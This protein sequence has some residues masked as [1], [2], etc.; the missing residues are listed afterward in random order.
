MARKLLTK[1]REKWVSQRRDPGVMRG[2]PIRPSAAVEARYSAKIDA[3]VSELQSD[4]AQIIREWHEQPSTETYFATDLSVTD[5]IKRRFKHLWVKWSR[6]MDEKVDNVVDVFVNQSNKANS[7]SVHA[8]LKKLSGGLSL[9]TRKLD[10]DSTQV[11]KAAAAENV[12]LIKSIPQQYL[13]RI[14]G[15]V[16]RSI[17]HPQGRDYLIREIK[18]TNQVTER[19]ATMIASDQTRKVNAAL[20]A[21]RMQKVGVKKFEWVHVA[22]SHPRELHVHLDGK[23]CKWD[24]PPV[25]QRNPIIKGYPAQLPNCKCQSVPVFEFEE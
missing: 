12:A 2:D 16:Y 8:S 23:I 6:M 10:Y 7:A 22:S 1:R 25:I 14:E 18:R 5:Y 4:V 20:T 9:G 11:L 3:L 13:Q 24:D 17:T 21:G 19:R 15:A